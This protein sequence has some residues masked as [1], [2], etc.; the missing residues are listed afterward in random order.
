MIELSLSEIIIALAYL[1][2]GVLFILGLKGL[3]SPR[4]ARKGNRM[5]AI[6]MLVAIITVVFSL[7]VYLVAVGWKDLTMGDD[8]ISFTPPPVFKFGGIELTE[9]TRALVVIEDLDLH[10]GVAWQER[11]A[12]FARTEGADW[13]ER[14]HACAQRQHRAM[15]RAV[16]GGAAGGCRHEYAVTDHLWQPLD[17]VDGNPQLRGLARLPARL[18]VEI[19]QV[20]R[21]QGSGRRADRARPGHQETR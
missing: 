10:D 4:T 6:G 11:A 19:G 18:V 14:E 1:A 8:G 7:I 2:A 3:T 21:R 16:V 13:R 15:G 5:A 9:V 17:V 12:P 20:A